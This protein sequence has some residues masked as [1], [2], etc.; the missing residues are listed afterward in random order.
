V[1]KLHSFLFD[2]LWNL[3]VRQIFGI[4]GDFV[5]NLYEAFEDDDRFRLVRLS[6]E[7]AVGFAADGSARIT[8]GLGVCCVTYGA[9]GL[10]LINPVACAYAEESPLLIISG[11]PGRRERRAVV[12]VHH[13]VKSFESQ[14][15]VYEEVTEYS[16]ILD[17]PRTAASHILK[18]LEVAT[19]RKRPVYLE[20]PRDMVSEP[21]DVP[22]TVEHIELKIDEGAI[23]EVA[24]EIIARLTAARNPVLI[25]GVE[26]HRFQL[27]DQVVRLAERL[28]IPVAS[29]FLGRGVFPTLHPQFAGT[30]LGVVSPGGLRETVESSDCVLLLGEQVSDT[31][32]GVSAHCL[33]EANMIIAVARDAF[34]GHHRYER[35]PLDRLLAR[36][37]ASPALPRKA[38]RALP[39][40]QLSLEVLGP[41]SDAEPIRMRHVISLIN[42]FLGEHPDMP[43][44]SDTGDCLFASVDIRAVDFIAP[45]YYATMGFSIPAAIGVQVSSGR[46]PLVL[47]GDGAFQ[48]TG[49][50]ISHAPAYGCNPVIV[51]LNN[52]QWGMLQAF[53]PDAR[54]NDTVSWPFARI[55]ELIGGRGFDVR[56]PKELRDALDAASR[57]ASFALIEV[58]LEADDRSPILRGFVE[59]FKKQ[60]YD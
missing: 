5:L 41:M 38:S 46:R 7:P 58:A 11:G 30:Y 40:S 32:L 4:P 54:Y 8:G 17:D 20:I 14:L 47:V 22:A 33:S 56:T 27:R 50:E 10:N 19:K 13:E 29:S 42:Q 15:K 9:G 45:A 60:V 59:A 28:N 37:L 3:G 1:Q 34:V 51:L 18:A 35:T 39:P 2:E 49:M 36:L 24:Q 55:V 53:F 25:V 26:I 57:G 52:T 12:H 21:L 6:H 43:L 16:A 31:S 23:N 44:V 48:M